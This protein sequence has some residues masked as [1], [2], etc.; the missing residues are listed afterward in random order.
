MG[1]YLIKS[2]DNDRY[3]IV[4]NFVPMK[5]YVNNTV[6]TN[7]R[8]VKELVYPKANMTMGDVIVNALS[9]LYCL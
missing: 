8:A 5:N 2:E 7:K 9:Q 1:I 3:L 6:D 4:N